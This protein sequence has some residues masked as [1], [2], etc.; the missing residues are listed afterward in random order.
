MKVTSSEEEKCSAA[1]CN[2]G[3]RGGGHGRI[4]VCIN[5]KLAGLGTSCGMLGKEQFGD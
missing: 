5:I 2:P 4:W 3:V 1:C